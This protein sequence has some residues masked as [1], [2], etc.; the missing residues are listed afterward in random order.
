LDS[1]TYSKKFFTRLIT[2]SMILPPQMTK[3]I[4]GGLDLRVLPTT[5]WLL[6]RGFGYCQI[7]CLLSLWYCVWKKRKVPKK[8]RWWW[9]K[10]W[11][12]EDCSLAELSW[13]EKLLLHVHKKELI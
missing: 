4:G 1:K 8:K 13:A 9:K 12:R 6:S 3:T 5:A 7:A 10:D 2:S 11:W